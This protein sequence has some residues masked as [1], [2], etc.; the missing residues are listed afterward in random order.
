MNDVGPVQFCTQFLLTLPRGKS[1]LQKVA[2]ASIWVLGSAFAVFVMR[3]VYNFTC[4]KDFQRANHVTRTAA[5]GLDQPVISES[6]QPADVCFRQTKDLPSLQRMGLLRD[7]PVLLEQFKKRFSK[8]EAIMIFMAEKEHV[9]DLKQEGAQ[10]IEYW[11]DGKDVWICVEV[12]GDDASGN[13]IEESKAFY[14]LTLESNVTKV[15]I[16]REAGG[17]DI[18][19]ITE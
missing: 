4:K 7:K 19:C 2:F 5:G 16:H 1:P 10:S 11:I 15:K 14:L 9:F 3:G 6:P 8:L 17:Y 13:S 12:W 18:I